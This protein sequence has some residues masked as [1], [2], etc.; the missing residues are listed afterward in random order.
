[1]QGM[2]PSDQQP[3]L[4]QR[5]RQT[6]EAAHVQ[7]VFRRWRAATGARGSGGEEA[8]VTDTKTI[9]LNVAFSLGEVVY[10]RCAK[11]CLPG[12]ITLL[13]V[14][15]GRIIYGVTWGDSRQ[16]TTH[17][18]FELTSEYLPSWEA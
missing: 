8:G 12:M 9:T 6:T 10:L 7:H 15:H 18:A 3:L 11:D 1:M 16:E 17:D 14:R 4:A 13:L 2:R 5:E